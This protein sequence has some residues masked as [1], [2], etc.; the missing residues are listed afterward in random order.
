VIDFFGE[1]CDKTTL[2]V[3]GLAFKSWTDDVRESP[4]IAAIRMFLERGMRIRAYDPEAMATARAEL[5][6]A[7]TMCEDGYQALEG[8]DA[9]V[10]FTDWPQF[11]TPDFDIITAK[12]RRKV[13]FDGRNLYD[14]RS[15][16]KRGFQYFCIGRPTPTPSP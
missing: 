8:A 15:L 11:R 6:E 1:S 13:L 3:W 9:L 12:L 4:A 2:A 14:P 5:G 16:A 7:V 10:V